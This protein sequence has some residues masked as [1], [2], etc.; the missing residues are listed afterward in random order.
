MWAPLPEIIHQLLERNKVK[1][2]SFTLRQFWQTK[3]TQLHQQQKAWG[4][5]GRRW[6]MFLH[7]PGHGAQFLPVPACLLTILDSHHFLSL[8][9]PSPR[10]TGNGPGL[11]PLSVAAYLFQDK[12][13][14]PAWM[15]SFSLPGLPVSSSAPLAMNTFCTFAW[16][17]SFLQVSWCFATVLLLTS[18]LS[19]LEC[20]NPLLSQVRSDSA[21]S[22]RADINSSRCS[23]CLP[24]QVLAHCC[25][26]AL[27]FFWP[28]SLK[29]SSCSNAHFAILFENIQF[30]YRRKQIEW[31]KL[32][33]CVQHR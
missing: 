9:P 32:V 19:C 10:P 17:S 18:S 8:K 30:C 33:R 4:E 31:I 23:C 26:I 29:H 25:T 15:Q 28:Q 3:P 11:L 5:R 20:C 1:P 24:P 14:T 12:V 16:F 7:S 22:F 2:A 27:I 6:T 21:L 13:R